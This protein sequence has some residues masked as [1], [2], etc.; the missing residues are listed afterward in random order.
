MPAASHRFFSNRACTYFPC[1]AGG[2]P[3]T[4]N[5]LFC[6]C[7]LYF[8]KDCGGNGRRLAS[9]VKDCSQCLRPHLPEA[10]D[11]ILDRLKERIKN[12]A[13]SQ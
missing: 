1:H 10:Y 2:D 7:P 4:F 12:D 11:E 8:D 9:G 3:E 5:C 6:Y 13:A